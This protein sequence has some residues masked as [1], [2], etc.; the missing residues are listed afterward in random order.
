MEED[1]TIVAEKEASRR[2]GGSRSWKRMEEEVCGSE[3]GRRRRRWRR[4]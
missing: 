1:A 2:R 4:M 3:I